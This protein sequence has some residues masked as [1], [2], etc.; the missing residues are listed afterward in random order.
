M[1]KLLEK[2]VNWFEPRSYG[3]DLEEYIISKRPTNT[4]E[5]EKYAREYEDGIWPRGL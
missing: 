1:E 5:V 2:L 4:A 3:S